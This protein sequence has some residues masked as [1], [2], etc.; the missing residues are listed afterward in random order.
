MTSARTG[1]T[2]VYSVRMRATGLNCEVLYSGVPTV[3]E[4]ARNILKETE[5]GFLILNYPDISGY[6]ILYPS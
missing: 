1:A 5:V 3:D 6:R 2:G 4:T